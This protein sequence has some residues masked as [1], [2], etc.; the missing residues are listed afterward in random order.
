MHDI[1]NYN[2]KTLWWE[3]RKIFIVYLAIF[4][5]YWIKGLLEAYQI[6][7]VLSKGLHHSS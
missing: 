7:S 5:Y 3:H 1:V 4:K 6:L 2:L